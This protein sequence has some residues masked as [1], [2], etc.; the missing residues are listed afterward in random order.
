MRRSYDSLLL[1]L[2]RVA[3]LEAAKA[4]CEVQLSGLAAFVAQLEGRLRDVTAQSE[5]ASTAAELAAATAA[6]AQAAVGEQVCEL[7]PPTD[8]PACHGS[9]CMQ[10]QWKDGH[11][12]RA[13][14][15]DIC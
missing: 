6:Q 7:L 9:P 12:I 14:G 2:Q 11:L 3:S 13:R 15:G 8:Q 5:A 1:L 4:E 10:R